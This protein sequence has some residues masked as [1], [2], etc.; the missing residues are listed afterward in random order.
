MVIDLS[1]ANSI[2]SPHSDS[3]VVEVLIDNYSE[4][5][6]TAGLPKLTNCP[7]KNLCPATFSTFHL[8]IFMPF[9]PTANDI[10]D[11]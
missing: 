8:D 11:D 3:F 1:I 7:S 4:I 6:G 10:Q 9:M 5:R 2:N